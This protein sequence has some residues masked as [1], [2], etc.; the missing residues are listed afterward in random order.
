MSFE[1]CDCS[2][3]WSRPDMTAVRRPGTGRRS[4]TAPW[5][6]PCRSAWARWC[7]P[8]WECLYT[9]PWPPDGTPPLAPGRTP[10][11]AP[12]DTPPSPRPRTPPA[13]PRCN[14]TGLASLH[15]STVESFYLYQWLYAF[16]CNAFY[17]YSE[18]FT[19]SLQLTATKVFHF[20]LERKVL[21][22]LT[23]NCILLVFCCTI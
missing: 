1:D 13:A 20:F 4:G 22:L 5:A 3:L 14:N 23:D 19:V 6:R 17:L 7:T 16:K 11:A 15:T 9:L 8:A 10:A 2:Y 21:T 18:T 12:A